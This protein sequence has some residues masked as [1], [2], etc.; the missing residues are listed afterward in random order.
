MLFFSKPSEKLTLS[1]ATEIDETLCPL[2]GG[3]N[4]CLNVQCG[5]GPENNC[6]CNSDAYR[7]PQALLDQVPADR[8]R[9]ACICKNCVDKFHEAV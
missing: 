2:C 1:H 3:D 7:F 6:W 5:G 9:K 4:A 8:K